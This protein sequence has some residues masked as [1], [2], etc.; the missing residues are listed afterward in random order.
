LRWFRH[1][2][3]VWVPAALFAGR[4]RAGSIDIIKDIARGLLLRHRMP[5]GSGRPR[6]PR[7]GRAPTAEKTIDRLDRLGFRDTSMHD[8]LRRARIAAE[9]ETVEDDQ[10]E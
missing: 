6:R 3:L 5:T 10:M 1:R 9:A 8:M 7:G 4:P 2:L